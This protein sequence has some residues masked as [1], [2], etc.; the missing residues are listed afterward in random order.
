MPY[1]RTDLTNSITESLGVKLISPDL[2]L[3]TKELFYGGSPIQYSMIVIL[4]LATGISSVVLYKIKETS[5]IRNASVVAAVSGA[6]T[7]FLIYAGIL[8][9]LQPQIHNFGT[10]VRYAIP[11]LL[12]ISPAVLMLTYQAFKISEKKLFTQLL[13][14]LSALAA[15]QFTPQA[16]ARIH[17]ARECG[18]TLAFS[19]LACNRNYRAYNMAVLHGAQSQIPEQTP[20]VD[21]VSRWQSH[22]PEGEALIAW[23]NAPFY[24]DFTRNKI[25]EVDI[26]GLDNPW[27]YLPRASYV[28]WEYNGFATRSLRQL[29]SEAINAPLYDR[30]IAEKTLDFINFLNKVDKELVYVDLNTKIYKISQ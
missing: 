2:F 10:S 15:I 23:I 29:N 5:S 3:S 24:L 27:A 13:S 6:L 11:F 9:V 17:Q 4:C 16:I 21:K 7:L 12:G 18:S 26:S 8:S 14:I 30:R 1:I 25:F 28:M 22:V 20:E 19:N